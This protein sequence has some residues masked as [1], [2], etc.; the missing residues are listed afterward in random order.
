MLMRST[1]PAGRGENPPSPS[2]PEDDV[3]EVAD[4][5]RRFAALR[6]RRGKS[7]CGSEMSILQEKKGSSGERG[8]GC[9]E[10]S[11]REV[12]HARDLI[13]QLLD[14][15]GFA[16]CS[17]KTRGLQPICGRSQPGGSEGEQRD[18]GGALISLENPGGL[19]PIHSRKCEVEHHQIGVSSLHERNTLDTVRGLVNDEAFVLQD[20]LERRTTRPIVLDDQ[21]APGGRGFLARTSPCGSELV[22]RSSA[23]G[24]PT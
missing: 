13:E 23:G 18:L 5:F 1:T 20:L 4:Y 10:P 8:Q 22:H 11:F 7:S 24:V 14:L 2:W 16:Q 3:Y 19:D 12:E 17:R 6:K 9:C 15:E 21:D